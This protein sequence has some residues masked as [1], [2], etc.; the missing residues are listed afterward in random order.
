MYKKIKLCFINY[1]IRKIRNA[2]LDIKDKMN[3]VREHKFDKDI[4]QVIS[5]LE[6]LDSKLRIYYI[7]L[8]AYKR[9]KE[10][11]LNKRR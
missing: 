8:N 4:I 1:H 3:W 2:I 6:Y 10:N 11:I 9:D 5:E 7:I